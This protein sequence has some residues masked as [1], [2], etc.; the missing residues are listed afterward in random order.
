MATA[1]VLHSLQMVVG[2]ALCLAWFSLPV[3]GYNVELSPS[4]Q[5]EIVDA[6]NAHRREVIPSASNMQKVVRYPLR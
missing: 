2:I 6:H 5:Q 4:E 3:V 1:S